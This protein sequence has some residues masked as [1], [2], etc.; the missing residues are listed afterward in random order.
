MMELFSEEWY[1]LSIPSM[2]HEE[3]RIW[4]INELQKEVTELSNYLI[5]KAEQGQKDLLRGLMNI[6]IPKPLS[7]E[8]LKIQDE[9]LTEETRR[10]GITDFADLQPLATDE[11]LYL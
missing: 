10:K 5:S 6:W 3:Q 1:A 9:Y 4:L 7:E 2:T 11:R 8:F